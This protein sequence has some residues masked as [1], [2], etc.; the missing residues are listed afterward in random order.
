MKNKKIL[1]VNETDDGRTIYGEVLRQM[2]YDVFTANGPEEAVQAAAATAPAIIVTD[3]YER[4][5][6]G[7]KTPEFLKADNRTRSI[8][9]VVLTAWVFPDDRIRAYESGADVFMEKPLPP[10]A[11]AQRITAFLSSVANR[12]K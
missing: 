4:T 5:V 8:P 9:L 7:W 1:L 12:S 10:T 11:F 6:H 3:V 2:G